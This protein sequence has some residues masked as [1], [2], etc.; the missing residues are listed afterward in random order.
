MLSYT[1]YNRPSEDYGIQYLDG[2]DLV[3]VDIPLIEVGDFIKV[4]EEP[5][6]IIP[7]ENNEIRVTGISRN[8]RENANISL[9]VSNVRKIPT[10]LEKLL[11]SVAKK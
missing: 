2:S 9:T 10:L 3:G 1:N 6:G 11:S 5:L 7:Y 4:T 8:L